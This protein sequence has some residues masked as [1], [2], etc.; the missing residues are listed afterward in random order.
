MVSYNRVLVYQI[1]TLGDTVITVPALK[2]VRRY[3]G[4]RAHIVL[5]HDKPQEGINSAPVDVLEG[6]GLVDDYMSYE[7]PKRHFLSLFSTI[8]LAIKIRSGQFQKVIYLAPSERSKARVKRDALFFHL[9]G[10]HKLIGFH[11]FPD[12]SLYP[13][14]EQGLPA[15]VQHEAMFRLE[16]IRLDGIDGSLESNLSKPFLTLPMSA[17]GEAKEWLNHNQIDP[18]EPLVAL[19]P[20]C[21]QPANAWPTDR[22]IEIGQRLI[23]QGKSEVLIVGGPA[24]YE[25]GE[26]MVKTWGTGMNAAGK[27]SVLISSALLSQC[28]FIVGLDTGTTHLAA[29]QGVPC[30]ALYGCRE[31]PGRF[32]PLGGRHIVLRNPVPCAGCRL[33]G[34]PCQ[35][36]GHPCMTGITVDKVWEAIQ[37]MQADLSN[38]VNL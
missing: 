29:A 16:R 4:S 28:K 21:K 27:F 11:T 33:I 18:G 14:D 30:V 38:T 9:C 25:V 19:C 10:I 1:G 35:E 17:I 22:F 37:R 24:E 7:I 13:V 15:C 3:F 2:A 5:M 31:E 32:Y 36:I 23:Q 26:Q 12:D 20:G 6:L 8:V 34:R